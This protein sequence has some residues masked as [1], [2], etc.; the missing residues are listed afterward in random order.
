MKILNARLHNFRNH[1]ETS[2]DFAA[3]M[4]VLLGENG[5][6]KTNALEALSFFCLT[7]SFYASADATVLMRDREFFEIDG[8]LE[9]DNGKEFSL[10]VAYDNAQ[11]SKKFTIN[12]ADAEKFSSVIGMFPV[13]VLSP[14]NNKVTF[15]A[16]NDRRKFIDLVISQSSRAYMEDILEYR[17]VVRQRNTILT[18]AQ[19]KECG[20]LLT[21]WNEMLILRGARVIQKRNQFIREFTPYIADTYL[22]IVGE[23][24]TPKIE[25]AP[26]VPIEAETTVEEIQSRL[27][28]KLA[29]KYNDELRF[30]TSLAGPHRDEVLLSLN[31]MQLKHFASQGQHKTYLVAL[32][33]A[34]FFYLKERCNETPV[35]LLD[36][37]FS[38]LDENRSQKLLSLVESLGQ[39]FITAT[40]EKMFGGVHWNKQR[41]KFFIKDGAVVNEAMAA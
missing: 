15:G 36:D 13:V 7:K 9:S 29:R 14:E 1:S 27:A 21:P 25:Y 11:K 28:Q 17:R 24:E 18:E 32:K 40:G 26:S 22:R 41:R 8:M 34:E 10:R 37:V 23:K 30:R 33:V 19:G 20:A 31:G 5:Q 2:F 16:P 6:G 35:F 12:N 3:R 39:T 4:N 38:E